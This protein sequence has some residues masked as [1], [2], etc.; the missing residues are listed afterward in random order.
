M[1]ND[2]RH[3]QSANGSGLQAVVVPLPAEIDTTNHSGV[4]DA[5]ARALRAR[6]K[7]V[8]ADATRTIFCDCAGVNALI[9]V[10]L[11]ATAAGAHLRVATSPALRH[12]LKLTGA[13]QFLNADATVDAAQNS[14]G[15]WPSSPACTDP[16]ESPAELGH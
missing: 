3:P 1:P 2:S 7:V 9:R 15:Q 8:I 12:I 16:R 10:H 13:D 5:L 4:Y 11:E 6:T 14:A